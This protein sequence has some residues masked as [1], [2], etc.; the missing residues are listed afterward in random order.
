MNRRGHAGRTDA[1]HTAVVK[2]L[3]DIGASVQ[4]L[5][6]VGDGCPDAVAA[7]YGFNLMIEIKDGDKPPSQRQLTPDEKKWHENWKGRI[8]TVYSPQDAVDKFQKAIA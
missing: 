4:S 5:A 7:K 3:R 1:N 8:L 6:M 2:A